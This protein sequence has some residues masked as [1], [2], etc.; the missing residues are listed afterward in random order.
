M[1][2]PRRRPCPGD[3]RA[4]KRDL[5]AHLKACARVDPSTSSIQSNQPGDMTGRPNRNLL[6][7]ANAARA[8]PLSVK[9]PSAVDLPPRQ[10]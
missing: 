3:S 2:G 4:R 6:W 8:L 5:N 1:Y 10:V 9:G 7:L